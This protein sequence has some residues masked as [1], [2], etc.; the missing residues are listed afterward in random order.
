[1]KYI[2]RS[3]ENRGVQEEPMRTQKGVNAES[4]KINIFSKH[5]EVGE[6]QRETAAT[7]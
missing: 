2:G 7:E 1:M 4:L 6:V 3:V 5:A